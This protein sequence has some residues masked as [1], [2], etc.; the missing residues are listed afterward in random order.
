MSEKLRI[1]FA[2]SSDQ[3]FEIQSTCSC[4]VEGLLDLHPKPPDEIQHPPLSCSMV[5]YPVF[6]GKVVGINEANDEIRIVEVIALHQA[7]QDPKG[8]GVAIIG[9]QNGIHADA[10]VEPAKK[11]VQEYF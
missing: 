1:E 2:D 7:L 11:G 3:T 10:F 6:A 5:E 4:V 8:K 9:H